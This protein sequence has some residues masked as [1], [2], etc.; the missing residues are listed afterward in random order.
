MNNE[1]KLTSRQMD[2]L[3]KL[4]QE[5]KTIEVHTVEKTQDEIADE[6]GITR[7]ALSNHL[8][9][10]KELGYI[11]T[12]RGFIDLTDKALE[13]LGEKKGDVFIFVRIE[14]TKRKQVYES[15][16]KLKIKRIHRVTGD[17]DL[18]VEADK[19]RLDEIL[20]EVASLDGVRETITHVVLET[21]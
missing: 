9:T 2:L 13:F 20:E 3:R 5:G 19:T 21:F 7:Q 4:Y 8:K 12:G 6:L 15:I 18:I 14:P 11:R 10:L 16:R 17:I 1:S